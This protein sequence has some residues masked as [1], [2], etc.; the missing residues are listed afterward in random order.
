MSWGNILSCLSNFPHK[1]HL[2]VIINSQSCSYKPPSPHWVFFIHGHTTLPTFPIRQPTAAVTVHRV[3]ICPLPSSLSLR[4]DSLYIVRFDSFKFFPFIF[5]LSPLLLFPFVQVDSDNF[6][7]HDLV[8][9]HVSPFCQA[10]FRIIQE[11]VSVWCHR[12]GGKKLPEM[13]VESLA[14]P[15]FHPV[16]SASGRFFQIVRRL[17]G[18]FCEKLEFSAVRGRGVACTDAASEQDLWPEIR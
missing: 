13:P 12:L 4:C 1:P 2:P 14:G 8:K 16:V 17:L 11:K 9:V 18:C 6:R 15:I 3:R 7:V 5:P 10:S